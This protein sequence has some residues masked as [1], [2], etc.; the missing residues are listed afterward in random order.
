ML[1]DRHCCSSAINIWHVLL[2]CK[3][4]HWL[5]GRLTLCTTPRHL[6]QVFS[7]G[8]QCQDMVGLA[9][10]GISSDIAKRMHATQ[11]IYH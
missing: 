1:A 11:G 3:F 6:L 4:V 5:Q 10:A 8:A 2:A 7:A 9:N